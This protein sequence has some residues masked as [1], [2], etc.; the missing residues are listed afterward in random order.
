[1]NL[2]RKT[3]S[4]KI[5]S[6]HCRIAFS[7]VV[8]AAS[9]YYHCCYAILFV[10]NYFNRIALIISIGHVCV[11]ACLRAYLRFCRYNVH[12]SWLGAIECM[13]ACLFVCFE[14][15]I[16]R[17]YVLLIDHHDFFLCWYD[18]MLF[19]HTQ[20]NTIWPI[21]KTLCTFFIKSHVLRFSRLWTINRNYFSFLKHKF[22]FRMMIN[23]SRMYN[24]CEFHTADTV[25]VVT[26]LYKIT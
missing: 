3:N 13:C 12:I 15:S 24:K 10:L 14:C 19:A 5:L 2:N 9:N 26:S 1:M 4:H 23:H 17:E 20:F 8:K 18:S 22:T 16:E 25:I 11:S 7:V 21:P 6:V